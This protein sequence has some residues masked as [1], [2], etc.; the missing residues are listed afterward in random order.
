[1]ADGT[2]TTEMMGNSAQCNKCGIDRIAVKK[3]SAVSLSGI[4]SV[5]GFIIG[6]VALLANIVVGLLII[7]AAAIIGLA[8]REYTVMVCPGCGDEGRRL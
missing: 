8:R 1:M 5:I 2:V 3:K 7:I 4:V 6:L